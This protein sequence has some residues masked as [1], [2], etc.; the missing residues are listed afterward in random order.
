MWPGYLEKSP[1]LKRL[2]KFFKD[3]GVKYKFIHTSGHAKVSDIKKLV[4]ALNPETI[5]PIHSFHTG[6]FTKFFDNVRLVK[7]R[8][9]VEV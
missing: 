5:I 1:S 9:V 7:D 2:Q 4:T 8:E 6:E 3:S